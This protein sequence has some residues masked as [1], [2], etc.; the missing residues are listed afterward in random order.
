[1][2]KYTES[3]TVDKPFEDT[4]QRVQ[5]ALM[6]YNW[7]IVAVR[8]YTFFLRERMSLETMLWRNPCRFA[9]QLVRADDARTYVNLIGSTLGFGPL[10][11]GRVRRVA[12]TLKSQLLAALADPPPE[13]EP[14]PAKSA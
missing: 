10:P 2:A 13:A 4:W 14:E 3:L 7:N 8:D 9:I 6:M 12:E 5:G 1:M 11:K